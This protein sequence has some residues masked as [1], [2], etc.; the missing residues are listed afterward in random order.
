M[1]AL[2]SGR[3][4]ARS[5]GC[6]RAGAISK[7][8][9]VGVQVKAS[10]AL[11][12]LASSSSTVDRKLK[13]GE[14]FWKKNQRME[15]PMSPHILIYKFEFPAL[16]S[17]SHRT[18]G[19]IYSLLA[20]GIAGFALIAPEHAPYY[21]D[22]IKAWNIPMPVL[23]SLKTLLVWPFF[24]HTFNGM[25]HLGWDAAKGFDLKTLYKTGWT[26]LA[27]ATLSSLATAYYFST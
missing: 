14:N 25:R 15:R 12:A 27:V 16:L 9:P 7:L 6:C 5:L 13:D 8:R 10:P 18:S 11:A 23:F 19:F 2:L 3:Y 24:Y 1:A 22:A 17:G 26:V 21:L 4:L 20:T